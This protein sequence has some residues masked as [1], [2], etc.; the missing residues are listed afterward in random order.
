[1]FAWCVCVVCN[2]QRNLT[3]TNAGE[4][5]GDD[6]DEQTEDKEGEKDGYTE[7]EDGDDRRC[8]WL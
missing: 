1:M 7:D 6:S 3:V 2:R 5:A 8:S 4:G